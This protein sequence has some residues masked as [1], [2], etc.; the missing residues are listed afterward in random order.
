MKPKPTTM[1][2]E[3]FIAEQIRD[4]ASDAIIDALENGDAIETAKFLR[5]QIRAGWTA[6]LDAAGVPDEMQR[7]LK[8]PL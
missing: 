2:I 7:K 5:E 1:K 6:A 4:I 8:F 3:S